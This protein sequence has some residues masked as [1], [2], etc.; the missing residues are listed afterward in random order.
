MAVG[1]P[2]KNPG[3]APD[4]ENNKVAI[5]I[6]HFDQA[7]C[8]F[9]KP[10]YF[11]YAIVFTQG[12]VLFNSWYDVINGTNGRLNRNTAIHTLDGTELPN[13]SG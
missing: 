13:D 11:L 9:V 10:T 3:Y 1:I 4:F 7:V 6:Y 12:D 8:I 2:F 5:S